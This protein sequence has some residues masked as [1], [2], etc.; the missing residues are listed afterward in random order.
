MIAREFLKK[1]DS[2]L[3]P[4]L[5]FC[6]YSVPSKMQ[7]GCRIRIKER[8]L[9]TKKCMEWVHQKSRPTRHF[10]EWGGTITTANGDRPLDTNHPDSIQFSISSH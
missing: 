2:S 7:F 1:L 8:P 3:S 9:A 4:K 10:S 5:T 6:S